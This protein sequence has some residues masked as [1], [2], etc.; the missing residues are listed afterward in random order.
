MCR[1]RGRRTAP[2]RPRRRGRQQA[3][4]RSWSVE[5]HVVSRWRTIQR[6]CLS[7]L[8]VAPSRRRGIDLA[9]TRPANENFNSAAVA[10]L[11]ARRR[12]LSVLLAGERPARRGG[13]AG[14]T[15]GSGVRAH[16]IADGPL[17]RLLA[18]RLDPGIAFALGVVF[19]VG[20][21]G[22][23]AR[24]VVVAQDLASRGAPPL[25]FRPKRLLREDRIRQR[26]QHDRERCR[27]GFALPRCAMSMTGSWCASSSHS[28]RNGSCF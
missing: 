22:L 18:A 5:M 25:V 23:G 9:Q 20:A 16:Q 17:V 11:C 24:R 1:T 14:V 4:G 26:H 28:R 13:A 8:A 6:K 3:P 21:A 10:E 2:M 15:R 12:A 7:R 19:A 27:Q